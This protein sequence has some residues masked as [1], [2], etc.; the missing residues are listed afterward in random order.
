MKV[1]TKQNTFLI[2]FFILIVF[3][4]L[5][6]KWYVKD[7][8]RDL[9]SRVGANLNL[10]SSDVLLDN[11]SG[12]PHHEYI[13]GDNIRN[14]TDNIDNSGFPNPSKYGSENDSMLINN[15]NNS[16]TLTNFLDIRNLCNNG[17]SFG[18][19]SNI[20]SKYMT[21]IISFIFIILLIYSYFF[22]K[23]E[24]INPYFI[25]MIIGGAIANLIDRIQNGCVYDFIDFHINQYHFYVFNIADSFITIGTILILINFR[26]K[27]KVY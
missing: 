8:F 18:I 4:D 9:S 13:G 22:L 15:N 17:V 5:G 1:I 14:N 24:E 11:H 10:S 26:T 25:L 6:S 16:I 2:L 3:L 20:E 21:I 19:L 27:K 23:S 7:L 12:D